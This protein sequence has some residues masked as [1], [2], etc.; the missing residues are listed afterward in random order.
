MR[1]R[2]VVIGL[3]MLAAMGVAAM[4]LIVAVNIAGGC[5]HHAP[6][7]PNVTRDPARQYQLMVLAAQEAKN[8]ADPQ[9]R[10][11]RQL[12]LANMQIHR[13]RGA[14]AGRTLTDAANTL[15]KDGEKL[16]N[17]QRLSGW[18]SVSELARRA[19][20]RVQAEAACKAAV[21]AVNN[22][23][24]V[25][26][27]CQYVMGIARELHALYGPP[28]AVE[29]LTQ[30]GPWAKRIDN[31][32][33]RRQALTGFAAALFNLDAFTQ[34]QSV[35]QQDDDPIWRTDTLTAMS[36]PAAGSSGSWL[37]SKSESYGRQMNFA[38][39]F[40]QQPVPAPGT[41]VDPPR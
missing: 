5:A 7:D 13:G 35:L 31:V 11:T 17:H 20:H 27:R 40:H 4:S 30:A 19:G 37:G 22:L 36:Q 1:V 2:H 33:E 6:I 38:D 15:T 34:G 16:T 28:N 24:N 23:D 39:N 26:E 32:G 41:P 10:L 3:V 29:L 25:P 9:L 21:E 14:D 8:I 18:V 12:N